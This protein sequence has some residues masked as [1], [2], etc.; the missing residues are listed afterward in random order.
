MSSGPLTETVTLSQAKELL[1]CLAHEQSVLLLS[2]PGVGKSDVV[3][4]AAA[5]AGLECKSLLGTQIAPQYV[6]GAPKIVGQRSVFGPA[7]GGPPRAGRLGLGGQRGMGR[8]ASAR[9]LGA[10]RVSEDDARRCAACGDHGGP[11]PL[12]PLEGKLNRPL[13]E[14]GLSIRATNC[15]EGEGIV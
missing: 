3:R 7:R 14:L 5:D 6:S 8:A 2:P 11:P 15:L 9:A 12:S 10:G 1:R 13:A 4:Q